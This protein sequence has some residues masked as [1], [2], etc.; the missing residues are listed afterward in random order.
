MKKRLII[1]LVLLLGIFLQACSSA[2]KSDPPVTEE[3]HT[4]VAHGDI[5]EETSSATSKPSFLQDKPED[6]QLIYLAV[7]Q[8]QE[9]LENMPCYCGCGDSVGHKDNYDCFIHEN[10]EDGSIVW[11]DH[12]TKCTVCLEIAAKA[13][14]DY[15]DGKTMKEIRNEIDQAYEEGYAN[16]TDTKEI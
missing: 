16:P 8:H 3:T 12:G 13:V 1:S 6:M 10:K 7:A 4:E 11:D 5:R 9:L 15:N 2:E 14:V